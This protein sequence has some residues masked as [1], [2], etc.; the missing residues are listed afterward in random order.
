VAVSRLYNSVNDSTKDKKTLRGVLF[1]FDIMQERRRGLV[2]CYALSFSFLCW[3][4][5]SAMIVNLHRRWWSNNGSSE[6]PLWY[7]I[8]PV[9]SLSLPHTRSLTF[10]L[11]FPF[12][13]T[14]E[15]LCHTQRH[16][17]SPSFR[18]P[19][20]IVKLLEDLRQTPLI[21]LSTS[22]YPEGTPSQQSHPGDK[23]CSV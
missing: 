6:L 8:Q 17:A 15:E 18:Y 13:S 2:A 14:L 22:I 7:E 4:N 23:K 16:L 12:I 3:Y 11:S 21:V 1:H 19:V 5:P 10:C 20:A 9:Q